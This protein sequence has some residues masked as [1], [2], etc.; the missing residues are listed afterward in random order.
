MATWF[1]S[2]P[3]RSLT[4]MV[5][6]PPRA[7]TSMCST[8][9]RSM[10]TVPISRV[11]L[12]RL[13]LAEMSISSSMLAP[14]NRSVSTPA[15][16]AP[17]S[18]ASPGFQT[19]VSLPAPSKAVSFPVPPITVSSPALPVMVSLPAPPLIVRLIWP[20]LSAEALMVS[21][22]AR[23]STLQRV[24]GPLGAFDRHL[25]R[26]SVDDDRC[27]AAGD[28]DVVVAGGAVDDHAV[29]RAITLAASRRRRQIER[30]LLHVGAGEIVDRD[31]VGAAQRRE[32]NVLDAVE[33]HGDAG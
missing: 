31:G 23:P 18:L 14:L 4:V 17:V 9:L 30:N 21:L 15:C 2:V 1:T 26:Q 16:P 6:A 13:P 28:V 25:R 20:G 19:N 32:L 12:A 29:G 8:P 7:L 27:A 11:S 3:L 24:V 10:V 5:S 33:V 22:P